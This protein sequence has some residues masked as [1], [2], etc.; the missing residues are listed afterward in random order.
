MKKLLLLSFI[1]VLTSCEKYV[2]EIPDLTLSGKYV[3]TKM[4]VISIAH[5]ITKDTTYLSGGIFINQSLP[6]PFNYI[7][8][9]DFHFLFTNCDVKMIWTNRTQTGSLKDTWQYGNSPYEIF[10]DRI[11]YSYDS[12]DYGKIRFDYKPINETSYRRIILHVDSDL[13]ESLQLSGLDIAPYGKDGPEY[14]F[15][16]TLSRVGP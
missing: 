16:F 6:H 1:L 9:N 2:T 14:R 11:P 3:V 13:F 5:A 7:K 15:I 12:Y 10:Y 8:V 4:T